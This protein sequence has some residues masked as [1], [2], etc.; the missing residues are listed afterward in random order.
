MSTQLRYQDNSSKSRIHYDL[1]SPFETYKISWVHELFCK[2]FQNN[3][4]PRGSFFRSIHKA[5][6]NRL[7]F[8]ILDIN[9]L[10]F[11]CEFCR[12]KTLVV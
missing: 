8:E 1:I 2:L 11:D 3:V 6:K 9:S 4:L 10:D 5:F 7:E 12:I